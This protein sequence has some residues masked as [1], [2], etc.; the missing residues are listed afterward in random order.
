MPP[1]T[2]RYGRKVWPHP[3]SAQQLWT[4]WLLQSI[5]DII[6]GSVSIIENH[7]SRP[8]QMSAHQHTYQLPQ[9]E[10]QLEGADLYTSSG[11]GAVPAGLLFF[12]WG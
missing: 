3:P 8:P 11:R 7:Q 5:C 1:P 10:Q 6:T 12:W 9:G 4:P 2:V